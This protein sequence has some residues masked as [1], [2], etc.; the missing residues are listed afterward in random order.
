MSLHMY[1]YNHPCISPSYII[2]WEMQQY[3]TGFLQKR[4]WLVNWTS[5]YSIAFFENQY[6]KGSLGYPLWSF[7]YKLLL[8]EHSTKINIQFVYKTSTHLESS[9]WISQYKVHIIRHCKSCCITESLATVSRGTFIANIW[10]TNGIVG[11]S[12]YTI[13]MEVLYMYI[14][15]IGVNIYLFKI[16]V[17]SYSCLVETS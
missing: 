7:V 9:F 6:C 5:G 1:T 8:W 16:A 11:M 10:N 17:F 3:M 13:N 12:I 2:D 4:L 14:V 15:R